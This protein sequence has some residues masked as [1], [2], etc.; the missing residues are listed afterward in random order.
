[1]T[2][3]T[4]SLPVHTDV[5]GMLPGLFPYSLAVRVGP[6]VRTAGIVG[7]DYTTGRPSSL[8]SFRTQVRSTMDNLMAVLETAGAAPGSVYETFCYLTDIS[9][10][11][12]F[13]DVYVEYFSA[14]MPVRTTISCGLIPPY[15]VEVSATAW[16]G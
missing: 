9:R 10:W 3:P 5:P 8:T 4:P 11:D 13:N 6:T 1:M 14:P 2:Q 15:Q 12:E 16:V 7:I